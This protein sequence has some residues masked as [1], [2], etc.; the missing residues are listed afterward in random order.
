MVECRA[1]ILNVT[2]RNAITT[3]CHSLAGSQSACEYVGWGKGKKAVSNKAYHH[4]ISWN[5]YVFGGANIIL[6][7]R[8]LHQNEFVV[9]QAREL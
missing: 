5:T 3:F 7:L 2:Q 1:V 8:E 9:E 6:A 4:Y